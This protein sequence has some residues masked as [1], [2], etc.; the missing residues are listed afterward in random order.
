MSENSVDNTAAHGVAEAGQRRR[1]TVC[2]G[3][4]RRRII[5]LSYPQRTECGLKL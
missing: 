5:E 2:A 3:C 4:G 1:L